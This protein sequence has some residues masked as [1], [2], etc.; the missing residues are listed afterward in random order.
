[1]DQGIKVS[2]CVLFTKYEQ[3]R[4][5][6]F[7]VTISASSYEKSQ[8]P[9]MWPYRVHVRPYRNYN[10]KRLGYKQKIKKRSKSR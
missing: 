9:S 1:M 7:K 4:I 5:L 3:A 8:D 2:D 10:R 6:S